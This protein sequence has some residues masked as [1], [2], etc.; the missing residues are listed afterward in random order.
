MDAAPGGSPQAELTGDP[1]PNVVGVPAPNDATETLRIDAEAL[2]PVRWETSTRGY[3]FVLS[4]EP[5][6][7]RPPSAIQPPDCIR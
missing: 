2:L 5:I 7:L 4:Y 3:D 6:D 1:F